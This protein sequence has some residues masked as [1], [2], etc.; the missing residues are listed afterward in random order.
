MSCIACG[1]REIL[2]G[3]PEKLGDFH[4]GIFEAVTRSFVPLEILWLDVPS[5]ALAGK[6]TCGGFYAIV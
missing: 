3:N 6:S 1:P 2:L 5:S 4:W